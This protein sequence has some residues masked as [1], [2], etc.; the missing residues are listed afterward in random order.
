MKNYLVPL[1]ALLAAPLYAAPLADIAAVISAAEGSDAQ[2]LRAQSVFE[3]SSYLDDEARGALKPQMVLSHY[4]KQTDQKVIDSE[5][6]VYRGGSSD[7]ATRTSQ[8]RIEQVLYDRQAWYWYQRASLEQR[9]FVQDLRAEYQNLLLRLAELLLHREMAQA[10][11]RLTES[12]VTALERLT[13]VQRKRYQQGE[14]GRVDYLDAAAAL[15]NS[16]AKV[17]EA[18]QSVRELERRLQAVVGAKVELNAPIAQRWQPLATELAEL[19]WWQRAEQ[20]SPQWLAANLR[21]E[22]A[23]QGRYSARGATLP[24]FYIA[25]EYNRDDNEDTVFGGGATVEGASVYLR[26]QWDLYDG[27]ATYAR[28]K[29]ASGE[30]RTAELDIQLVERDLRQM[31]DN[32]LDKLSSGRDQIAGYQAA[33]AAAAELLTLRE[34]QLNGGTVDELTYLQAARTHVQAEVALTKAVGNYQL[35]ILRLQHAAGTLTPSDL[36]A[37]Q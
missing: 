36:V 35:S 21:R 32:N 8:L 13:L 2:Y 26:A 14:L 31:L 3:Q 7:F 12:D 25:L 37:L 34:S 24:K 10:D 18:R 33:M 6:A 28:V 27:G 15:A 30:L 11:L 5:N 16:R 1:L 4:H 19:S 20:N 9:V 23:Q 22:M 17:S 29:R